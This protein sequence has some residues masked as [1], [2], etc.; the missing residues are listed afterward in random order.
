M[1]KSDIKEQ[2]E[3]QKLDADGSNTISK[4]EMAKFIDTHAELWAMLVRSTKTR[5][6]L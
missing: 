4:V 3:F 1:S 6:F 5:P 2:E